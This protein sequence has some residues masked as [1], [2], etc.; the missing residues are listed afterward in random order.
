MNWCLG[1]DSGVRFKRWK[2]NFMEA[3]INRKA[4]SFL[5]LSIY[6][7]LLQPSSS[8]VPRL[9][10]CLFDTSGGGSFQN[11]L[12][13]LLFSFALQVLSSVQHYGPQD[14]SQIVNKTEGFLFILIANFIKHFLSPVATFPQGCFHEAVNR[15][16]YEI[17]FKYIYL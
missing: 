9:S 15:T 8:G 3:I 2:T 5:S 4:H 12:H 16:W 7:F 17:K 14:N 11:L 10:Q 6:V 1:S 13:C